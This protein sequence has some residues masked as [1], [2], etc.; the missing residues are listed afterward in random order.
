MV[1]IRRHRNAQL[2][3]PLTVDG[4]AVEDPWD[5]ALAALPDI[6]SPSQASAYGVG[7]HVVQA[8]A[9]DGDPNTVQVPS[10]EEGVEAPKNPF[11]R[12]GLV[13]AISDLPRGG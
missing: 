5:K 3:R 2:V 8:L 1:P 13:A 12:G 7:P 9:L 4:H 6:V 10:G 11:G